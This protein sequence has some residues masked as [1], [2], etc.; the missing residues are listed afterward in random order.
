MMYDI[1]FFKRINDTFGHP[2]GDMVI[3]RVAEITKKEIRKSD[4]AARYGGEEFIVLFPETSL[5]EAAAGAER[6]RKKIE[7]AI[8]KSQKRSISVTASFGVSD[9]CKKTNGKP[10]EIVLSEFI[11]NADQA[12]YISK[13]SGRN[14]VTVFDPEQESLK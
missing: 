5:E 12:L 7:T 1:D 11:A 14:R 3:K 4:I 9:C 10:N 2:A 8:I 6:V 13:N